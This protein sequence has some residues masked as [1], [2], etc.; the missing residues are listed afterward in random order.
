MATKK[1]TAAPAPK[2]TKAPGAAKT[3]A[4]KPAAKSAGPRHPHGRV[5]AKHETKAALA[6][7]L[8]ATLAHGD[9]DANVLESRLSR[10]SNQQLL[11]LQKVS[12][13]VA[14]RFGSRDKL[15]AAIG[16]ANKKSKDKDFIAKLATYSLPQLLA[17]A[18]AQTARS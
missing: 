18:P 16:D 1:T 5:V 15:I 2:T 7:S 9:E 14:S 6:K 13:A 8:A 4:A 10:A 12:E 11:R 3:K 17:I